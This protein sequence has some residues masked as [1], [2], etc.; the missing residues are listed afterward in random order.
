[1]LISIAS[2]LI[3]IVVVVV[4]VFVFVVVV[5][6]RNLTLKSFCCFFSNLLMIICRTVE[7]RKKNMRSSPEHV[8]CE[9][10]EERNSKIHNGILLLALAHHMIVCI[11]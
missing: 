9:N 2:K 11:L 1:M 6:Y 3:K 4:I 7:N 10:F 8:E 5:G